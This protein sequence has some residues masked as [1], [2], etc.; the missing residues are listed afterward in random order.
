M[1]CHYDKLKANGTSCLVLS[2]EVSDAVTKIQWKTPCFSGNGEWIVG[3]S[4]NKGEHRL[5]IWDQAGRLVKI[6]EGPKEALIDLAW[7]PVEPT[8]A[9]VSV[10][11][12]VYIWAKEHVENW[13]AF[14]PDFVELEE[15]EEYVEKEDEFDLNGK[16]EKVSGISSLV[17]LFFMEEEVIIDE[18]A[19]IDIETCEKNA[20]F[21]DLEDSVDEIV[22]LPAIPSPDVPDEQPDKCLGSSSKLEDSNHSGSPS[23]MDAVQN[24]QAIPPASSPIEAF[25][26]LLSICGHI[27]CKYDACSLMDLFVSFL[28]AV[29]NSTAEDPGEGPNSKRKRRL[30][31][32]GLE[33]QQ[34]EK[35]KKPQT[36][37]KAN[38]KSTKSNGKQMEITN[39]NSSAIDDEATEDDEVNVEN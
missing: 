34:S 5:Q 2:C 27:Y 3:G 6:L 32:K 15:N 37:I 8:I 22:H 13:S 11:G 18:N 39:G 14:A 30:S 17:L 38:G 9:T 10:T 26:V 23:S 28:L 20:V 24:G 36:K 33:M 25:H 4:A 1:K 7:H 12:V 31:A 35:G 29:D 21:S 19:E 16:E